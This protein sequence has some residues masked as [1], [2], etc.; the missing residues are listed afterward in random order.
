MSFQPIVLITG[1]AGDIGAALI[2]A[3]RSRYTVVGLDRQGKTAECEL[4]EVDLTSDDSVRQAFDEF[5][6]RFGERIT[7]V[8]HLAAYFDFSGEEHPLYSK[9]NV[10][11]THRLLRELRNFQVERLLYPGT[12]LVHEPARAGERIDETAPI[13]PKWAYPKSKAAAEDVIRSEHGNIPIALLHLAGLYDDETVVPTLA[14]QIARIYERD[15]Q[16]H[17]YSGSTAAGQSCVHKEDMTEAFVRAIERRGQLPPELT[18]LVGEEEAP[19]YDEL[20]DTL[21]RLIHGADEWATISV[22]KWAAKAGAGLQVAAEPLIPDSID[23]GEKPFM[24]PFMMDLA[25]DH[26]ELDTSLARKLL[27]WRPKHRLIDTL[28]SIVA[29]LKRDPVRWYRINGLTPPEWLET[30]QE[31]ARHPEVLRRRYETEFRREYHRYR[32]A[33]FSNLALAAWLIV[34]PPILDYA[35]T[36]LAWSDALSGVALLVLASLS[37]S[38]RFGWARWASAA[39]GTWIMFAPLVFWS[40]NAAAYLNDTLVGMLVFGFAVATRPPP[41]VNPVA[42]LTGPTIPP[43]WEYSPSG[44]FQ[45]LPIILLAWVGFHISRYLTAYQLGHIDNVWEPFFAG[46]PDP[47]NGTE[48]IITS[49]LSKAWPVPD[50]G[51]GALTYALEILTGVIG[52]ARRWRTMPW[53]VILFGIMIVPL[54]VVSITFIIVQPILIGTW[55]TLCLIAAAAMLLQIPYS[56]D[57]IVATAQ[58]LIRRK[59]AGQSVLRVFFVGDTDEG[60]LD[61]RDEDDFERKPGKLAKEMVSGGVSTPW[62]L[63]ASILVG[64]WLMCTRLTVGAEGVLANADHLIGALAITVA[65]TA[66]AEV[67]RA[68]RYVNVLFGVALLIVPFVYG[69]STPVMLSEVVCGLLLILLSLPRGAIRG[70]YGSWN[71]R[72]V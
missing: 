5:R 34:S 18:L 47:Q 25:Q 69:A 37:L 43:G 45:R 62:N 3:L 21:G 72:I 39:L 54:G 56:L 36:P 24:R 49:S 26:Y 50:A 29:S 23:R 9:V 38:W 11:G 17:L 35:R 13:A 31:K 66:F 44:W 46:G 67:G 6:R 28:P 15:L 19:S 42:A 61:K 52:S 68:V 51:V 59:R 58:F 16:S 30:V 33:H 48:E 27:G 4:I 40:D 20:Q 10:E 65:I 71:R 41:G 8:I 22:P 70:Q 64:V 7:S 1:A 14:H 60:E 32:W 53:L 63:I 55:C 12:M 57:E 2:A